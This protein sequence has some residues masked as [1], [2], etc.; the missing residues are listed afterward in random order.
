[1]VARLA[2]PPGQTGASQ[3]ILAQYGTVVVVTRTLRAPRYALPRRTPV[4]KTL[5][6]LSQAPDLEATRYELN[7]PDG[8]AAERPQKGS[9]AVPSPRAASLLEVR[10][11]RG[12]EHHGQSLWLRPKL[13]LF[14]AKPG[15]K[16]RE[17]RGIAQEPRLREG[18]G[19]VA[20]DFF[21]LGK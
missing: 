5:S 7:L 11:S 20:Q 13:G 8:L 4:S 18:L 1:M 14:P 19:G 15:E 16:A 6:S 9:Q 17:P 2:A 21:A 10:A 12:L 3:R